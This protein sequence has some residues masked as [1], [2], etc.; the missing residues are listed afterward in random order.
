MY[1]IVRVMRD[2]E[3]EDVADRRDIETAGGDVGR[4]QKLGFAAAERIERCGARRLVEVAV[5]C[6]GAELVFL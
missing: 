3:I 4:Y 2:V 1:V 6:D 5:Q